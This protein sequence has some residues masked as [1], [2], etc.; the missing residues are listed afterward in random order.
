[1]PNVKITVTN[2][3]TSFE[4]STVSDSVGSYKVG[5]LTIGTYTVT[6]EA[7][8][9]QRYVQTDILL[10]IGQVQRVDISMKVG[11]TTQEIT[12]TGNLVKVQTDESVLSSVVAG[13]PDPGHQ[14]QWTELRGTVDPGPRS[15]SHQQ[16]R[17]HLGRAKR[18]Y[19]REFQRNHIRPVRLAG[20]WRQ[21]L[22]LERQR[23]LPR[24]A[25]PG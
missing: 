12:V 22:Q 6:A 7:P 21:P 4:A 1:M 23:Q 15:G 24:R 14:H 18:H 8:G 3:A 13:K 17:P 11:T 25:Q 9:F 20:R 10:Q 2:P 16:L 19:V 5:F